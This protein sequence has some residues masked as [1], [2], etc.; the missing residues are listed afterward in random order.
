MKEYLS[1]NWWDWL[2]YD[3][4][5]YWED[6]RPPRPYA[7]GSFDPTNIKNL[8]KRPLP[9]AGVPA[10]TTSAPPGPSKNLLLKARTLMPAPLPPRRTAAAAPAA[11]PAKPA[12]PAVP[13]KPAGKPKPAVDP[14]SSAVLA[15]VTEV[16]GQNLPTHIGA[17]GRWAA[18]LE[19]VTVDPNRDGNLIIFR[20]EFTIVDLM[21]GEGLL[22]LG[23]QGG[24]R[25]AAEGDQF[26]VLFTTKNMDVYRSEL[27]KFVCG[28][29]GLDGTALSDEAGES[30][31]PAYYEAIV[32][33]GAYN[34][35]IF[36]LSFTPDLTKFQKPVTRIGYDGDVTDQYA[37]A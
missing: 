18:R 15:G 27:A 23:K 36:L 9:F 28:I 14:R 21:G 11:A 2:L 37:S 20:A 4:Q 29:A 1:D 17:S 26:Q 5:N 10:T 7:W 6:Y 35:R 13:A 3:D 16:Y 19:K 31:L 33:D 34:G 25:P 24:H 12:V 30:I 22:P 8:P 32:N